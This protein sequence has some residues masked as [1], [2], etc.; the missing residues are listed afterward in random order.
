MNVKIVILMQIV[1]NL[2]VA[3]ALQILLDLQESDVLQDVMEVV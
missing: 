2:V 1:N 3:I